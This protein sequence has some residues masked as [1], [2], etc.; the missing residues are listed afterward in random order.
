LGH[1]RHIE[2]ISE[3]ISEHLSKTHR[4]AQVAAQ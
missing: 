2:R 4:A 3:R 1:K